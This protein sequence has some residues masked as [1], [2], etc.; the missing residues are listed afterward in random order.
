MTK[1]RLMY[2]DQYGQKYYA[3]T[4]KELVEKVAPYSKPKVSIM[5][6]D[7]KDG[8]TVRCGYVIGHHW[9][10]AYKPLEIEA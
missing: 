9:L 6:C 5:Y 1:E 7:K 4:R 10:T 3:S 2:L 8:K